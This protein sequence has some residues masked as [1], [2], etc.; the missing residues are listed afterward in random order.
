MRRWWLP[1]ILAVLSFSSGAV[2]LSE[3][4]A[5]APAAAPVAAAPPKAG[6]LSPRRVPRLLSDVVAESHLRTD[7]DRVL[8]DPAIGGARDRSCLAVSR[9]GR[10]LYEARPDERLIPASNLKLLTGL[11]AVTKLGAEAR[12]VTEVRAGRAPQGGVVDGDLWLVG[13]GDPLLSTTPYA[14]SFRNQPQVF[15]PLEALADRIKEAGVTT[16]NGA[17]RGD[18]SRYDRQRYLPTWKAA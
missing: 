7:L 17:V 18:E 9:D 11:A 6:I 14:S 16:V 8:A 13:G 3:P 4:A 15:T 2:A 12:F 1:A 10:R 5:L